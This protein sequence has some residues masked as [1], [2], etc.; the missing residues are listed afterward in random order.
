MTILTQRYGKIDIEIKKATDLVFELMFKNA[1]GQNLD[2][3]TFE[4]QL[5]CRESQD[6]TSTLLF[7]LLNAQIPKSIS[8]GSSVQDKITIDLTNMST[9]IAKGS[10]W[11][12]IRAKTTSGANTVIQQ[13]SFD[14]LWTV[15][16]RLT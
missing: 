16:G 7:Q 3:S 5:D 2:I 14:I 10:Y 6:E 4:F 9:D 1:Q 15:V 12:E 13:G 8:D 11:Y